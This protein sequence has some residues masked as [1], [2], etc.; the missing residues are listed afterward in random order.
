MTY[1]TSVKIYAYLNS[2]WTDLSSYVV[3]GVKGHWGLLTN[4]PLDLL[5]DI[6]TIEFMLNNSGNEFAPDHASALSGWGWGVPVKL[7]VNFDGEDYVRFYGPIIDIDI[8]PGTTARKRA[9]VTVADWM[10]YAANYP[11]VS[12]G[13]DTD[14]RGD[15][16]LTTILENMPIQPQ[17]TDFDEG[18]NTFDY[19]FDTVNTTTKAYSEASKIAFSEIGY[20]YHKKDKTYGDTLV[21]ESNHYR[22]GLRTLKE[23]P[24]SSGDSGFLLMETGD[25]LLQETG[26]K[27]ILNEKAEYTAD[28]V[29]IGIEIDYGQN[30][31]NRLTQLAYPKKVDGSATVLF[32]LA[33]PMPIGSGETIEFRGNYADPSGGADVSGKDMVTPVINTDYKV[34]TNSDGTGTDITANLTITA[35]YGTEGVSY[36]LYNGSAYAG[37]ITTLQARGIGIYT[38][39]PI[40]Y[41]CQDTTSINDYGYRWAT[42]HQKYQQRLTMG[43]PVIN[44]ILEQEKQPRT[45]LNKIKLSANRSDELMMAFLNIHIGDLIEIKEDQ[46]GI[47][48]YYFLQGVEFEIRPGG[49]IVCFSWIVK[50]FLSLL[51]GLSL[52]SCEFD[53]E[54]TDGLNF[55]QIPHICNLTDRSFAA[56]VYAHTRGEGDTEDE[57]ILGPFSDAAGCLLYLEDEYVKFYIKSTSGISSWR[58]PVDSVTRD[59]WMHVLVT[60]AADP[61]GPPVIYIDGVSQTLTQLDVTTDPLANET[62]CN[63][64]IGNWKTATNDYNRPFDGLI[65]EVQ[66]H[67][68][69]LT[70]A[71][72]TTLAGGGEVTRGLVFQAPCV[73]TRELSDFED[74]TLTTEKLL[75][76]IFGMVGTP[77][78]SVVTRLIE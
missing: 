78:G 25:Y 10:D 23:I 66:V 20:I 35:T 29:A 48:G 50:E 62:G 61:T 6:G 69:N 56:R 65:K 45:K 40:E 11:L 57:I 27:I 72:A 75:D 32:S 47:D 67:N 73:R 30:V 12:P 39:N 5:A 18:V 49:K 14:K 46:P 76:N 37:W 42:L 31:I 52:I 24:K 36:S 41:A 51:K 63:F 8:Q 68:V 33:S 74:L 4:H 53:G 64:F 59:D 2:S 1:P 77:H 19:I 21:F 70:Q 7:V 22:H 16:A 71:E 17:A 3:S 13:I 38:Y 26:D 55:G 58:T 9:A 44:A 43:M 34:W 28:N 15:E 60:N 54:S